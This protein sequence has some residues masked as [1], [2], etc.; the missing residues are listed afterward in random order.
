ML[1]KLMQFG[2]KESCCLSNKH[3]GPDLD[4]GS[5]VRVVVHAQPTK[6]RRFKSEANSA[7]QSGFPLDSIFLDR[8]ADFKQDSLNDFEDRQK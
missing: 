5:V 6:A 4:R 7:S 2:S 3:I 8:S 1:E